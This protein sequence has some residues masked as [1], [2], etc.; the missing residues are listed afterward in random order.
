LVDP[1]ALITQW[2]LKILA[3]SFAVALG[4]VADRPAVCGG[5]VPPQAMAEEELRSPRGGPSHREAALRFEVEPSDVEIYLDDQYL[6]RADELRGRPIEGV[7]AGNRLLELRRGADRTFLQIVV[8]PDG[9]KTIR[10]NLA[11]PVPPK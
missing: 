3:A 1:G 2:R 6:G 5:K 9:A 10:V 7:V 11:P 4:L 8:P